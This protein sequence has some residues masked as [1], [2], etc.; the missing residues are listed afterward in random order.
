MNFL[1]YAL[2]NYLLNKDYLLK[3]IKS[4]GKLNLMKINFLQR[5]RIKEIGFSLL[6]FENN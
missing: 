3:N 1:L 2:I 4:F 5:K 6:L